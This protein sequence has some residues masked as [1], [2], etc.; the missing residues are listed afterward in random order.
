MAA[1]TVEWADEGKTILLITSPSRWTWDEYFEM[2]DAMLDCID[3]VEY[4]V[5][6]VFDYSPTVHMPPNTISILPEIARRVHPRQR[7][8]VGVGIRIPL[9][10]IG[11]DLF[12][13]TYRRL[14]LVDTVEEAFDL[15][16]VERMQSPENVASPG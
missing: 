5:S 4:S 14:E 2:V 10:R 8:M 15:L 16:G 7:V 3:S 6:S 12:S 13:R 1:F 9:A 11:A